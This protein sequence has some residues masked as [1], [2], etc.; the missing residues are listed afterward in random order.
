VNLLFLF[1]PAQYPQ[2]RI[3]YLGEEEKKEKKL[4]KGQARS[5]KIY[6]GIKIPS[7]E[8]NIQKEAVK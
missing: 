8:Y 5:S 2:Q 4:K 6:R 7:I 1:L 3:K